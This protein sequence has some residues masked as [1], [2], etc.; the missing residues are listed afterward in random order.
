M[1]AGE[2]DGGGAWR[3]L[4]ETAVSDWHEWLCS[5]GCSD[6][7]FTLDYHC[8]YLDPDAR[9]MAYVWRQQDE[10]LFFPFLLRSIRRVGQTPVPDGLFDITSVYGY[11]G[12]LST[13]RSTDTLAAAWRG[14]RAWAKGN[15]VVNAFIR[16]HPLLETHRFAP[17]DMTVF[18]DR[19]TV[20]IPLDDGP[21]TLWQGY[22]PT[23]RN[24]VR[25]A[26]SEGVTVRRLD[27]RDGLP[28]FQPIYQTT[29]QHLAADGFYFF[30]EGYF[31]ALGRLPP[32]TVGIFVAEWSGQAIAA[33]LFFYA[34]DLVHYH[35]GGSL[36]AHRSV[37]P[38][39]LLFHT[40]AEQAAHAGFRRLHLGGGRTAS[41]NDD[42]LRFKRLFSRQRA[43]FRLGT[44]ICDE[45]GHRDLRQMWQDQAT[46]PPPPYFQLYRLPVS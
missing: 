3:V 17:A 18:A 1:I 25:K 9:P 45:A 11:S 30:S 26:I 19:Q 21:E 28:V 2:R 5:L 15:G 37:A 29:M 41:P 35:L 27:Y 31:A 36:P 32:E 7:Y 12:P 34:G 22:A 14:F 16:F 10:R 43:D 6:V 40:V 38:N 23:Q 8:A 33:A 13:C 20:V 4:D 42:L 39:N 24:R 46:V 44:W